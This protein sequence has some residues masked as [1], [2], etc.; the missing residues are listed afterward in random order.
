M[1]LEIKGKQSMTQFEKVTPLRRSDAG[2]PVKVIAVTGGKGGVG[3]TSVSANLAL[4]LSL[5]NRRVMLLDG[6][7]G[8]ANANLMFGV[9]PR[10]TL[11]NVVAGNCTLNEA[12][13]C[14]PAGLKLVA[15][16]SGFADMSALSPIQHAGIISAFSQL[17]G[18]LDVLLVDT[19]PGISDSVLQFA[20]AANHALVLVKDEPASLT[21]AYAIIK[22]LHQRH[23]VER[24]SIV[25][26]MVR[27][28]SGQKVFD[29][30]SRTVARFLPV[31]LNHMGSIPFDDRMMRAIR[32]QDPVITAFPRSLAT[33]AIKRLAHRIDAWT[34][35]AVATGRPQF[36]VERLFRGQGL[37]GVAS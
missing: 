29:R 27:H 1:A 2:A 18:K 4:A 24:F 26:N 17:E 9:R 16:A 36:F 12:V 21:D 28:D 37:T 13:T 8:L 34:P 15:G 31:L 22:L 33:L 35:P 32:R 3:K 25:T 5:M 6:D 7:L 19:A 23:G 20:G 30:L 14:G 11:R 10:M